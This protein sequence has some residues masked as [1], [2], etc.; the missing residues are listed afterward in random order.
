MWAYHDSEWGTPEYEDRKLFEFLVLGGAQ[1][2]LNWSTILARRSGYQRAFAEF[3]MDKVAT[4][5]DKDVDRLMQFD[6]IIRNR[7][8]INAA[9]VNARGAL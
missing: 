5:T 7:A 3:D 9:I 2:G 4:F 1:A 6:G 8:K